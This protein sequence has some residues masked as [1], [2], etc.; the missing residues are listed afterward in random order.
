MLASGYM[1]RNYQFAN[2]VEERNLEARQAELDLDLQ[3]A[4][5]L[6][7]QNIKEDYADEFAFDRLMII[8]RRQKEYEKEL[9]VLSRGI[10]LFQQDMNEHLKHALRHRIDEKTLEQLSNAIIKKAGL[11]EKELYYPDPVNRWMKRK[12]FVEQKLK[13]KLIN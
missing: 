6:Y 8:Y 7:E 3:K 9:R 11:K 10:E 12:L 1:G 4:I 13:G 2:K 5:K